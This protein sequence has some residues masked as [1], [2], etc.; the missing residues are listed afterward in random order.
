MFLWHILFFSVVSSSLGNVQ[1]KK[2]EGSRKGR[3]TVKN[4]GNI[5]EVII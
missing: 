1:K 4:L 5:K 3:S 2:K